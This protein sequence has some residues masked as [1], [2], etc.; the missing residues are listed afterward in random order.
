MTYTNTKKWE[1]KASEIAELAKTKTT[2][3]ISE[4]YKVTRRHMANVLSRLSIKPAKYGDI[5]HAR[6]EEIAV[7]AKDRTISEMA[8][9]YGISSDGMR[10]VVKRLGVEYATGHGELKKTKEYKALLS[11]LG[12]TMTTSQIADHLGKDRE[13]LRFYMKKHGIAFQANQRHD[14]G[15]WDAEKPKLIEMIDSGMTTAEIAEKYSCTPKRIRSIFARKGI[16][17]KRNRKIKEKQELV[18]KTKKVKTESVKPVIKKTTELKQ[19]KVFTFEKKQAKIVFPEG[20]KI[21]VIKPNKCND[22]RNAMARPPL[23]SHKEISWRY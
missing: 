2:I 22:W 23:S 3:Q 13:Y 9:H 15:F 12:K 10:R 5:W 20:L 18:K 17:I 6:K 7:M 16:K 19:T 8:E 14:S 11:E 21:Q 4:Y 1:F